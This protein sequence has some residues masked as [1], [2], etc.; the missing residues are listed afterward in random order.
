M[1][2]KK[3]NASRL[4]MT[5][6]ALPFVIYIIAFSYVPIHGWI[7][8]FFDYRPALPLFKNEFVGLMNFR[9]IFEDFRNIGRVL[10]NTLIFFGLDI[11]T[12]FIPVLL[13][14]ML[15]EVKSRKFKK[16]VQTTTTL[17]Y[18]V[19]WIIIYSFV[20]NLF[21]FGGLINEVLLKLNLIKEPTS[22]MM[23]LEAVYPFQTFLRLWKGSGWN[24]IIY[25]AAISGIDSELYDAASVDGAGRFMKIAHI[26]LPGVAPTYFVLLLLSISN[27][28]SSGLDQYL[29][30]YN[31]FVA[32]RIEVLDY[33]VYKIGLMTN[34]YSY[35]IA[36]GITKTFISLFLLFSA[37]AMAKKFRGESMF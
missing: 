24:A 29:V 10:K 36:V 4:R 33:Y 37:N 8:A 6:L 25:L 20:F 12:S 31:G 14:I 34:D 19:S 23:N 30:F 13:A 5:L 32:P 22:I 3:I 15:S 2:T 11:L 9:H 1:R 27:M 17:P 26:T 28:L 16:L 18:F 35:S 7:Y 21:S